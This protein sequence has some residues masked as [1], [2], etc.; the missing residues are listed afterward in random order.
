MNFLEFLYTSKDPEANKLRR[1]TYTGYGT[2][3]KNEP[4]VWFAYLELSKVGHIFAAAI[5]NFGDGLLQVV[6]CGE[7]AGQ[8]QNLHTLVAS[9]KTDAGS[10]FISSRLRIT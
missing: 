1:V 6:F 4:T 8:L 2:L 3:A 7:G 9:C 5:N 10:I